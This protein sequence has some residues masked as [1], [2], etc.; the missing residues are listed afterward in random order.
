MT[1]VG[2]GDTATDKEAALEICDIN[3]WSI[4]GLAAVGIDDG[5]MLELT[6]VGNDD[7]SY[8]ELIDTWTNNTKDRYLDDRSMRH[9]LKRFWTNPSL[10][11]RF[12]AC[13]S[14]VSRRWKHSYRMDCK[15]LLWRD[16]YLLI[17]CIVLVG[18]V[19][20][21]TSHLKYEP[22][23]RWCFLFIH[24]D[25]SYPGWSQWVWLQHGWHLTGKPLDQC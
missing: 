14:M 21:D 19:A 23:R 11:V 7:G 18:H 25:G 1:V 2:T 17:C 16:R 12:V 10:R 24:W 20:A 13:C 3:E 9:S 8:L 6:V 15:M 4:L 22:R 5:S